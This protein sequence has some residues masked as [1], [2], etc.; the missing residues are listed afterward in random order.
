M[1]RLLNLE[2]FKG[3]GLYWQNTLEC[4][5]LYLHNSA[6]VRLKFE[7]STFYEGFFVVGVGVGVYN[8]AT[9]MHFNSRSFDKRCVDMTK[10]HWAKEWQ[11]WFVVSNWDTGMWNF[12]HVTTWKKE[13]RMLLAFT[14]LLGNFQISN[15]N[16][17]HFSYLIHSLGHLECRGIKEAWS[18]ILSK[19]IFTILMVTM[20]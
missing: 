2:S 16:G 6:I 14:E 11:L 3:H 10:E 13:F 15:L 9:G 20:F 18:W 17:M 7:I 19:I 12:S 4:K 8:Y 1:I 5:Y